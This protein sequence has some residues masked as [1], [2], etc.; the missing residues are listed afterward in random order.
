MFVRNWLKWRKERMTVFGQRICRG[1]ETQRS[2]AQHGCKNRVDRCTR[3]RATRTRPRELYPAPS[4]GWMK[5]EPP[6]TAPPGWSDRARAFARDAVV[7]RKAL[8]I[9]PR[10][11]WTGHEC[12][13]L[14]IDRE[15]LKVVDIEVKISR[16]DLKA[17]LKKDKWWSHHY[18]R[19]PVR[20]DWP[21]EVWRHYYAFPGELWKPELLASIPE[22]SGLVL[23]YRDRVE[24]VTL[25][26]KRRAKPN[27]KAK[28]IGARDAIDLARLCG[29]RMWDALHR[30]ETRT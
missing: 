19:P 10:C 1:C 14:A 20:R 7:A 29:L 3:V 23:M 26:L 4:A 24:G 8:L 30:Q 6:R 2:C 25:A 11:H 18:S 17:D 16:A 13:L 5:R 9:V 21:P 28:P 15:T 27:P 12:D 22:T